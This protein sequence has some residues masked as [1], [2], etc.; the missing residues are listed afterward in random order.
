VEESESPKRPQ[1]G[2]SLFVFLTEYHYGDYIEGYEK[3]VTWG[4]YGGKQKY[5]VLWE[6]ERKRLMAI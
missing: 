1:T 6:P 5:F 2:F 3:G 4:T